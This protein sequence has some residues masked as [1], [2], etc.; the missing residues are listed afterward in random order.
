MPPVLH[1]LAWPGE[2]SGA[3]RSMEESLAAL[4]AAGIDARAWLAIG[5]R[6]SESVV[7]ERLAARGIPVQTRTTDTA[8][9]PKAVADLTRSLRALGRGA[10]LHTHGERA[11]LWGRAAARVA[12]ARH[13]HTNHGFV[14]ND[15]RDRRRV[16]AARRLLRS[17]D[18]V[19]AVHPAAAAALDD[20]PVTVVPNC[21]DAA[22]FVD[23][24]PDRDLARRRLA[25]GPADRCFLFCGRLEPEKGA[26]LLAAVQ[27]GLQS[28]SAAAV[29]HV[30]GAGSLAPGVE[31]MADVRLL[32][33]RDAA[34]ALLHAADVVLMPSRREGLPMVALE[35][36]AVG[37]PLVGFAVGGLADTGLAT[38]VPVEDV[39]ALVETAL[40][41]VRDPAARAAALGRAREALEAHAPAAHAAALSALY[42]A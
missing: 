35:A 6:V 14:E 7:P 1:A 37:T 30:A 34:A 23:A 41:L 3:P 17:V 27:A 15:D 36:A 11:L 40:R 39:V 13:V 28:R 32:G 9:A 24:L 42:D 10:V 26:D 22:A 18:A 20:A 21:L 25:L 33:A 19:V 4:R 38:P 2:L 5:R 16:G 29:L 12:R 31:A 8:V